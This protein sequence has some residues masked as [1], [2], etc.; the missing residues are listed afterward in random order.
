MKD[1]FHVI[2]RRAYFF[3]NNYSRH[4]YIT[5]ILLQD[6]VANLNGSC[7]HV[8]NFALLIRSTADE[9]VKF[10]NLRA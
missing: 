8:K 9:A 2:M 4:K 7:N 6:A 10:D 1:S 5:P 3:A